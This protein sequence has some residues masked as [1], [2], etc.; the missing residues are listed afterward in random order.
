MEANMTSVIQFEVKYS[1][2]NGNRLTK[3]NWHKVVAISNRP[4]TNVKG[5]PAIDAEI[6]RSGAY[7]EKWALKYEPKTEYNAAGFIFREINHNGGING[8]HKTFKEA[9]F[10]AIKSY[11]SV[12]LE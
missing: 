5:V 8:H 4:C 7:Y 1:L 2:K 11:I 10:H 9:V 3:K 6:K 12:M